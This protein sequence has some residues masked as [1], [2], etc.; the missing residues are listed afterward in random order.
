MKP[1]VII[2]NALWEA[3]EAYDEHGLIFA[4]RTSLGELQKIVKYKDF[5]EVPINSRC[6]RTILDKVEGQTI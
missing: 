1:C 6:G 5:Q 4:R 3:Y 2:R